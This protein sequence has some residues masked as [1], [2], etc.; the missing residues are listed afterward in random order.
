MERDLHSNID[1]RVG[2][3]PASITSDTTTVGNIIDT[4]GYESAAFLVFLGTLTD[5]VYTVK[6]EDGNDSGLSDA[7][8]IPA[9][10]LLGALPALSVSDTVARV[11]ATTKKRYVRLSI[12]STATT[13]GSACVGCVV[14]LG[15]PKR[16]P[17]AQ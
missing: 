7:A 3:D 5:G 1:D 11:G 17:V 6:L 9:A 16:A 12:V 2:L 4:V 15:H 10:Q 14:V 13:S 8:D